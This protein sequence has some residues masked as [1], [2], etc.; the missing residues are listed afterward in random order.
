MDAEDYVALVYGKNGVG[1]DLNNGTKENCNLIGY[2]SRIKN[3]NDRIIPINDDIISLSTDLTKLNAEKTV[4]EN[5]LSAAE[6]QLEEVREDFELLTG[7]SI[8]NISPDDF[9]KI[10]NL[11]TTSTTNQDWAEGA[12][13]TCVKN[14]K[15]D[16]AFKTKLSDLQFDET[17]L[18]REIKVYPENSSKVTWANGTLSLNKDSN[19]SSDRWLGLRVNL[20]NG[21]QEGTR[22]RLSFVISNITG[23]LDKIGGH[24]ASFANPTIK[25]WYGDSRDK[26]TP[27]AS[28]TNHNVLAVE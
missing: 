13:I 8:E 12:T 10:E 6:S 11:S 15:T 7:L 26:D 22:Y 23:V 20:T 25:I 24:N 9:E 2:Y 27:D 14:S 4:E 19:S 16:W 18:A 1:P 21:Y 28:I 5:L 3:L 17:E